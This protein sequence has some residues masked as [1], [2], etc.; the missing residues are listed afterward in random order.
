M[1]QHLTR[2]SNWQRTL[3]RKQLQQRNVTLIRLGLPHWARSC[4]NFKWRDAVTNR[5]RSSTSVPKSLN[6]QAPSLEHY[7]K[8]L[9]KGHLLLGWV[10]I[11]MRKSQ[12]HERCQRTASARLTRGAE[13][14]SKSSPS[15]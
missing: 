1:S 9:A 2:N 4:Y 12:R 5:S 14:T 10:S 6:A 3:A 15:T 11:S 7:L 8:Y 13:G